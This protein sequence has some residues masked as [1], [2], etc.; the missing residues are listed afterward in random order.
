MGVG[1]VR[2]RWIV[3]TV[4]VVALVVAGLVVR[5]LWLTDTAR[6]VDAQ[7]AVAKFRDGTTST[8]ASGAATSTTT[9]APDMPTLPAPGVYRYRTTGH[10]Q[11]DAL[12]G[13]SHDYPAETTITVTAEGCGA[14]LRWDLLRERWDEL[15]ICATPS[16]I[17]LQPQSANYHEFYQHGERHDVVCDRGV[18]IVPPE[19]V[20]LPMDPVPLACTERGVTALPEWQV[21]DRTTKV[22]D[23]QAVR[24]THV[25]RTVQDDDEYWEHVVEDWWFDDHGLPVEMAATKGN[26][27]DSDLVGDVIYA[28]EYRASLIS[29][30]PLT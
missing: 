12:G 29:L 2:R 17:E 10:E 1:R 26:K 22:V 6:R 9:P 3:A 18:V 14:L 24:V 27:T 30:V 11:I 4:V 5:R 20:V 7:E 28:E 15:R 23:G 25:R 21:L 19:S 16:G 13:T 8:V